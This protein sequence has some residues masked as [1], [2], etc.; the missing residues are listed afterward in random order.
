MSNHF[1]LKEVVFK[2][3]FASLSKNLGNRMIPFGDA[4]DQGIL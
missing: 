3:S 2:V 1:H 4:D